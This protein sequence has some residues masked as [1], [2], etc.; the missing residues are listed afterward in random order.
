MYLP[1]S[2]KKTDYLKAKVYTRWVHIGRHVAALAMRTGT[3]REST[4]HDVFQVLRPLSLSLSVY[5]C[6]YIYIH[7]CYRLHMYVTRR[8]DGLTIETVRELL[9]L[10]LRALV[11]L[12]P[13]LG[14][15]RALGLVVEFCEGS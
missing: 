12:G 15:L 8:R 7:I 14:K 2:T 6:V 9:A 11:G 3:A 1:R 4:R 5:A 13:G 10:C